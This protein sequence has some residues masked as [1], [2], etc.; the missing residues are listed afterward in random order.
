MAECGCCLCLSFTRDSYRDF[1]K[2][3]SQRASTKKSQV[4]P[5]KESSGESSSVAWAAVIAWVVVADDAEEL[6]ELHDG[7]KK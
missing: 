3:P 1:K 2:R 4:N 5:S 7:P 6:E